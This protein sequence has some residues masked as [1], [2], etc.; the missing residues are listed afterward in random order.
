MSAPGSD[1]RPVR[2]GV[3]GIN[4]GHI[5]GQIAAVAGAGAVPAGFFAAED[6][7]AAE[8]A[9]RHPDLPRLDHPDRLLDDPSVDLILTAAIPCDRAPI[10][11]AAMRRG[12]DVMAD[13]PAFVSLDQLAEVRQAQ[14]E[15]GRIFSVFYG[16][17][18]ASRCTLKALDLVRAGRI[19]RA[20]Q[21]LGLGPHRANLGRRPEWFT[22]PARYGGILCDIASHQLD[23][24]LVFT[25]T[26]EAEVVASAV[27]NYAHPDHPG[28]EDY[29][30]VTVRGEGTHGFF[31]VDWY[32]PAGLGTWGDGRLIVLGTEGYLECRKNVD[33][34]GRPGGDHLIVV[35]GA[36]TERIDCAAVEVTYGRDLVHDIRRR[37]ETAMPQAHAFQASELALRAQAAA[38]RRG[39]L[40]GAPA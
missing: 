2:Y 25:G 38:T 14:R 40:R 19:G 7:L 26:R 18:L 21:V 5:H 36:G 35:D 34:A 27:A 15:T 8:F 28:L 32:T 31:R 37:T 39:H 11:I 17:R 6:D 22:D 20:V 23:Q 9:A 1:E 30:E 29:G 3:V 24:F 33:P 16:E 10:G 13:K 12:K 4:H